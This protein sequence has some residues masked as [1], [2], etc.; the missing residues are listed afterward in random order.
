MTRLVC[1]VLLC[2]TARAEEVSFANEG[3]VEAPI[4][5]VWEAFAT[6]EGY[7]A[8]GPALADVDLRV[9]GLIRSLAARRRADSPAARAGTREHPGPT[10]R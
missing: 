10:G 1:L 9:G 2:A 4:A 7:K 6:S 8:L 5:R 3:T